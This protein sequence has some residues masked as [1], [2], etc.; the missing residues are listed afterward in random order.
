[1]L[2]GGII[3]WR[4][5]NRCSVDNNN[6]QSHWC[7]LDFTL[8]SHPTRLPKSAWPDAGQKATWRSRRNRIKFYVH[9]LKSNKGGKNRI[10]KST[11]KIHKMDKSYLENINGWCQYHQLCHKYFFRLACDWWITT[12]LNFMFS[13]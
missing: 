11:I 13:A 1:M 9:Q 10:V 5:D 7:E 8:K 12:V 3:C 6:N 2:Q 4:F